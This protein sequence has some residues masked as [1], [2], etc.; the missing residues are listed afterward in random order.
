MLILSSLSSRTPPE[1]D[2]TTETTSNE[3]SDGS[4]AATALLHDPEHDGDVLVVIRDDDS[5]SQGSVHAVKASSSA[6]RQGCSCSLSSTLSGFVSA[7]V[8]Q[9]IGGA[10]EWYC[11]TVLFEQRHRYEEHR[12][13]SNKEKRTFLHM[14]HYLQ[15]A[16]AKAEAG[17]SQPFLP[18]VS[19]RSKR[20]ASSA[21]PKTRQSLSMSPDSGGVVT[22]VAEIAQPTKISPIEHSPPKIDFPIR[23]GNTSTTVEYWNYCPGVPLPEEE[24]ATG[25]KLEASLQELQNEWATLLQDTTKVLDD[26]SHYSTITKEPAEWLA[27]I[28]AYVPPTERPSEIPRWDM[29]T[30]AQP[31][32]RLQPSHPKTT[33]NPRQNYLTQNKRSCSR[34]PSRDEPQEHRLHFPEAIESRK[35]FEFKALPLP[36]FYRRLRA[37]RDARMKGPPPTLVVQEDG[38]VD[39]DEFAEAPL[40]PTTSELPEALL[41]NQEEQQVLGWSLDCCPTSK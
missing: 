27:T 6:R 33:T 25:E 22:N 17:H 8:L 32:V 15:V 10:T 11:S 7:A 29:S 16:Q 14:M 39:G 3:V 2:E 31:L 24:E 38:N 4:R 36:K 41:A 18:P 21:V 35:Q 1:L 23:L 26:S 19:C 13:P 28:V 5:F 37:K 20:S 34:S 12:Q 9:L 30:G 40:A